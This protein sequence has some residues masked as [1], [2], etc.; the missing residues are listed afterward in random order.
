MTHQTKVQK[1][2]NSLGVRI[3]QR[4]AVQADFVEGT[5]VEVQCVDGVLTITAAAAE[6]S[7]EEMVSQITSDNRHEECQWG[8]ERGKEAW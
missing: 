3:P 1:W 6:Y 5:K 4:L 7:L 8:P 2:G